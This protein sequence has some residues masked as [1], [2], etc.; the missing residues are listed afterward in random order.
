MIMAERYLGAMVLMLIIPGIIMCMG[1]RKRDISAE[2][3]STKTLKQVE[4]R[5]YQGKNLSSV[6]DFRENSI[7]SPQFTD[8][9]T[10]RLRRRSNRNAL[11]AITLSLRA[12]NG[13]VAI[14]LYKQEI[15]SSSA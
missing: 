8:R 5:Q 11:N 4:V 2:E 13:S 7:K 14:P 9:K 1:C 3:G 6:N 12:T 10:H 15:A